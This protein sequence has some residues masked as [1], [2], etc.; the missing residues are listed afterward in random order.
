MQAR[1]Q[2]QKIKARGKPENKARG[3]ARKKPTLEPAI[4]T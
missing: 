3:E 1:P 2:A 4:L